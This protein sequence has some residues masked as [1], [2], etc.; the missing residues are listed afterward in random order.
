MRVLVISDVHAN[1]TALNAVLEDAG[2][3][4]PSYEAVWCLG[5][6]VGYGPDPNECVEVVRSLPNLVSLIGNHDQAALGITPLTRFNH[7]ARAAAAWTQDVLNP[8]SIEFLEV[9]PTETRV[10]SFTLAHGS[11]RQPVWEYILDPRTA[12]ANFD[13]FET[14]YCL[15]GHSHL[16]LIF[17]RATADSFALS[18][19]VPWNQVSSL[20]PRMILNPGSV[21][22]PRDMDPRAAYAVLDLEAKSWEP[23]R[24]AYDISEVQ[25]RM[26]KAG[27]PERQALRLVAGW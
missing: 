25:L 17:Q 11:P 3:R 19:S 6:L 10:D 4:S 14:D 15:V 9:L 1:L 8:E 2:E 23:R 5:D 20:T 22:Q 18:R 27:L 16:P 7:D 12:D 26:L 13:E 21:G 24:A